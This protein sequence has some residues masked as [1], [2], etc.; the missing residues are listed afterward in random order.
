MHSTHRHSRP[1]LI[2]SPHCCDDPLFNTLA[3]LGLALTLTGQVLLAL[4]IGLEFIKRGGNRTRG[5]IIRSRSAL[6]ALTELTEASIRVIRGD[7][8]QFC[9]RGRGAIPLIC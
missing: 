6:E 4:I 5:K 2:A 7:L 8:C 9:L 1:L 3:D